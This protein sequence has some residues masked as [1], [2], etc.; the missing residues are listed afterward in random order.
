MLEQQRK[1][2]GCKPSLFYFP[3]SKSCEGALSPISHD[4]KAISTISDIGDIVRDE[5]ISKQLDSFYFSGYFL[6]I[7]FWITL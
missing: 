2:T 4:F 6:W 5:K 3:P 1:D 7:L